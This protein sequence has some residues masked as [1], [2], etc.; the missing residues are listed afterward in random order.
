[1][2]LIAFITP[3][4]ATMFSHGTH[5]GYVAVPPEHPLH[6]KDMFDEAVDDALDV[7]GGI[8]LSDAVIMPSENNGI[9]V[10]PKY[11]GKRHPLLNRAEYLT[12]EKDIP[13]DWWILGFD[14]CH[15]GDNEMIWNRPNVASE[16]LHLKEQL[17]KLAND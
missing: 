3:T 6:G 14:T 1:M 8:T 5:N 16:T 2:K 4:P 9:K 15:Y 11:V 17:E 10:N 13:D 7:H 12:E